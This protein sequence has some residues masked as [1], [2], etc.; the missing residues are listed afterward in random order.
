[1]ETE[2][3]SG[4]PGERNL[5]EYELAIGNAETHGNDFLCANTAWRLASREI[6]PPTGYHLTSRA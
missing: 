4:Y 3:K 6:A 5:E 2:G 1:M